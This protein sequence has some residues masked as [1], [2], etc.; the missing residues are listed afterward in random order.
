M[1]LF[2]DSIKNAILNN[3][4]GNSKMDIRT[5][6]CLEEDMD[7]DCFRSEICHMLKSFGDVDFVENILRYDMIG[8]F[9]SKKWYFKCFYL[10]AMLDY[11][12]DKYEV[13]TYFEAY[14]HIR[15]NRLAEPVFVS[16]TIVLDCVMPGYRQK[17][18]ADC[19]NDPIGRY[20]MKYNI[21][22]KE[23]YDVV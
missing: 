12:T 19:L 17:A 16:G 10:L 18:I 6:R 22:E 9:W 14:N 2:P 1:I 4:T 20:F 7:Q 23:I 11:L 8:N 21:V 13:P 3:T 5:R 15:K